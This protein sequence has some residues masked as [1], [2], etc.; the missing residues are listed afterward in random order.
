[1]SPDGVSLFRFTSL[2]AFFHLLCIFSHKLSEWMEG[3][4]NTVW[5]QNMLAPRLWTELKLENLNANPFVVWMVE[6]S[7]GLALASSRRHVYSPRLSRKLSVGLSSWHSNQC[8]P[9]KM[10]KKGENCLNIC[11]SA[12]CIMFMCSKRSFTNSSLPSGLLL[13]KLRSAFSL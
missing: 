5:T 6:S 11:C 3:A 2:A 12:V 7:L 13:A 4:Q 9:S 8:M 10:K 1:M